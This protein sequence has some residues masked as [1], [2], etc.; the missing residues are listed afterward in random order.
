M[1]HT[2]DTVRLTELL[3]KLGSIAAAARELGIS[4]RTITRHSQRNPALKAAIDAALR[5]HRQ[6][7]YPHGRNSGYGQ[8]CRC[9]ACSA[10]HAR[11]HAA[12]RADR[13]KHLSDATHGLAS[14]YTN[15]GCRCEPCRAAHSR[16]LKLQ[17]SAR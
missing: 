9:E 7:T 14:T 1:T 5:Q 8:G 2:I 6:D 13:A 15:W 11:Y 16:R 4:D 10:V 12:R 17:R 3:T